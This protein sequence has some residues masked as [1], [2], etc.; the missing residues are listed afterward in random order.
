MSLLTSGINPGTIESITLECCGE[1]AL[2]ALNLYLPH[3]DGKPWNTHFSVGMGGNS[4][5][6]VAYLVRDG[7]H[8]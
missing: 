8:S 1:H 4:R 3:A 5:N 6:S 2:G 7:V